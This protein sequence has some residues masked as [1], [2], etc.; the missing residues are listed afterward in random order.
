M[1]IL[2]FDIESNGLHG[3]AFAV[4]AVLMDDHTP[5]A[6]SNQP[7]IISEFVARC[8]L[9]GPIDPWVEA[10]VLPPMTD[11]P[12]THPDGHAMRDAFW[13]WYLEAR[14]QA[15][16]IL[17][18]NPYPVEAR[19]LIACQEDDMASR[20]QD[21]PFPLIDLASLLYARG[22]TT[23]DQ[24]DAFMKKVI[25]QLTDLSHNPHW[26]AWVTALAAFQIIR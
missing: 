24:R 23:R 1:T 7:P 6:S 5:G 26:D 22:I 15:D 4:G 8:P 16:L 18:N 2:S 14:A 20:G 17:V 19:F 21:H 10:N 12:E 9:I 13:S 3:E 11:I 25:D